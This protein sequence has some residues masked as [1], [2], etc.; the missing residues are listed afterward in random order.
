MGICWWC[1]WGWPKPVAEIYK[2]ALD[3]LDGYESPLHYGP[4]H[5]VWADENWDLTQECL[6]DFDKQAARLDYTPEE[7]QIVK[8][9]LE[10]LA[11]LPESAWDI[12]PEDYDGEHPALYPPADGIETVFV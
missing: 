5:V 9:S 1:Y 7:M 8:E 11:A 2:K 6:G 10:E 12:I 4:S 3:R